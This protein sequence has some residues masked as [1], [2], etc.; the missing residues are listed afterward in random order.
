MVLL[1]T[2]PLGGADRDDLRL[3]LA[4]PSLSYFDDDSGNTGDF[5]EHGLE[6]LELGQVGSF[7]L[8]R[9]RSCWSCRRGIYSSA[10]RRGFE[11]ARWS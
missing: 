10:A 1:S 11:E 5:L 2:L 3:V 7:L 4:H 6:K 8:H 9:R